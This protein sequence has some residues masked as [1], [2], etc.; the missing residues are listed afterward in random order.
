[1][2]TQPLV[3]TARLCGQWPLLLVLIAG[4]PIAADDVDSRMDVENQIRADIKSL[5]GKG[6]LTVACWFTG[7][8]MTLQIGPPVLHGAMTLSTSDTFWP[9]AKD[10]ATRRLRFEEGLT[11]QATIARMDGWLARYA[12]WF[13]GRPNGRG[14]EFE[15]NASFAFHVRGTGAA[16]L[17]PAL[18]HYDSLR[19]NANLSLP[20]EDGWLVKDTNTGPVQLEFHLKTAQWE[21]RRFSRQCRPARRFSMEG[22][23]AEL[24]D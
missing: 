21:L 13:D 18:L 1:M 20:E 17:F 15:R 6:V 19:F 23:Y 22:E 5:D 2:A 8:G 11:P 7:D 4:N 24:T 14:W 16:V 3:A 9:G 12:L 10:T